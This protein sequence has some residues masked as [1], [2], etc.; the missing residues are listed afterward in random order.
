MSQVIQRKNGIPLY[1]Q[2]KEQI[3]A[4]IQSGIYQPGSQLPTERLL[5]RMIGISRNTVSQAYREL[6][7]DGVVISWQGR[8]TFVRD[9]EDDV[10]FGNR[11]DLLIKVIDVALEESIQLGFT[12]DDFL[13][14]AE[15]RAEEKT[16]QLHKAQIVFIE[17]NREQVEYLSRKLEFG[18]VHITPVLIDDLRDQHTYALHLVKEAN[19]AVTT[20]FHYDEVRQILGPHLSVLAIA[21]DPEMETIVKMARIPK[22]KRA[23]IICRSRN[24]A[25]K[26]NSALKQAGIDELQMNVTTV[27][28]KDEIMAYIRD[29]DVVVVSPGRRREVEEYCKDHQTLI[30]FVFKPDQASISLL[31]AALAELQQR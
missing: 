9:Q 15:L 20:F 28:N 24:F 7:I 19:L 16:A 1:L 5:S 23:G 30:E 18:G 25:G 27:T 14:L 31:R 8:G 13:E 2:V 3:L 11:R 17:C 22:G 4:D 29:L 10:R 12:F 26:V 6:E 21:L